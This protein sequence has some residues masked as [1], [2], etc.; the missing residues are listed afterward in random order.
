MHCIGISVEMF[1]VMCLRTGNESEKL[2]IMAMENSVVHSKS[3]Q[4]CISVVIFFPLIRYIFRMFVGGRVAV[5]VPDFRNSCFQ[6]LFQLIF[7]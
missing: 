2:I 3:F 6:L 4:T 1:C 7:E 5:S